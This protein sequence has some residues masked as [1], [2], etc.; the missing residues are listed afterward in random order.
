MSPNSTSIF[1]LLFVKF[2]LPVKMGVLIISIF[3]MIIE[4]VRSA[5]PILKRIRDT[6]LLSFSALL[7]FLFTK[8]HLTCTLFVRTNGQQIMLYL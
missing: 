2:S 8:S 6:H 7:T 4:T 5:T 1:A 3:P